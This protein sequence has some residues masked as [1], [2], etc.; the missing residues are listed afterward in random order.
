MRVK[1]RSLPIAQRKSAKVKCASTYCER[2][3]KTPGANAFTLLD[4]LMAVL[5]AG[6]MFLSLMAGFSMSFQGV[7]IDRENSR[8]TQIM[9]EKTEL[10]RLYTWDESL[11]L[12]AKPTFRPPYTL[13]FRRPLH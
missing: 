7:R 10:L 6:I 12:T 3:G 11:A 5:L 13:R 2:R 4:A 1:D 8:A 9:L